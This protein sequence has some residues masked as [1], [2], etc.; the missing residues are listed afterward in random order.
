MLAVA[1][2]TAALAAI[3]VVGGGGHDDA[4]AAGAPP[5][6]S[7][8]PPP[9]IREV[10]L[11][12]CAVCH[13][14]DARGTYKAPT[15]V[16]AGEALV[17]YMVASGNMPLATPAKTPVPDRPPRYSKRQ[18]RELVDYVQALT[19]GRG[20]AIPTIDLESADLSEGARLFWLNCAACH[21]STGVGGALLD[22]EAP[23]VFEAPPLEAASAIR[24]G[25]AAMPAFGEAALSASEL[26]DV[27]AYVR[28]LEAPRNEG[29]AP[30]GGI[31]PVAEGAVAVV[32]GLGALVLV[33]RWIGTGVKGAGPKDASS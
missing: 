20:P 28:Y 21:A 25:P 13:G 26:N 22:R 14:A 5:T 4:A 2:L 9:S 3:A 30:I 15:L 6:T 29:G 11:S 31:G 16:G 17:F 32:L 7:E 10:F 33:I 19:G 27:V 12:D 23:P 18:I 1:G 8:Q 24:T